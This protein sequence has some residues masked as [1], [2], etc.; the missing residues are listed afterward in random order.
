MTREEI[1]IKGKQ[2]QVDYEK[3][4]KPAPENVRGIPMELPV[5]EEKV[6]CL[7]YPSKTRK[8]G[9]VYI[10]IHGGGFLWGYPEEDDLFCANLSDT[11]DIEIYSIEYPKTPEHMFPA[12]IDSVYETIK[13]LVRHS[14]EYNFDP[15]QVAVGGHS[16]GGNMTAGLA[17]R[18]NKDRAFNL[19]CQL[20]DYPAVDVRVGALTQ[21]M[22]QEGDILSVELMDFFSMAYATEEDAGNILCNPIL[23]TKED[24]TGLPP[25]VVMTCG[26]D[27]LRFQGREYAK[28]LMDA[29]VP[30]MLFEYPKVTHAFDVFP[31]P[32]MKRGQDFLIHGLRFFLEI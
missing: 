3:N 16:A 17:I 14:E 1:L 21:D 29:D 31:G 10:D 4:N 24:L 20:L 30:V 27:V 12:G 2:M 11:L 18:N 15:N 13:Y 5:G 25:A 23:A 26:N 8:N 6:Y 32:D 22:F 19:K 9:P 7:H 28:M